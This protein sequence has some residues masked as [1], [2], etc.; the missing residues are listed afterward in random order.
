MSTPIPEPVSSA[1]RS[2]EQVMSGFSVGNLGGTLT[3]S[4]GKIQGLI[5]KI[6]NVVQMVFDELLARLALIMTCCTSFSVCISNLQEAFCQKP[7]ASP[8]LGETFKQF[9]A[10][11][12][13]TPVPVQ[14]HSVQAH[15]SK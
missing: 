10:T 14:A 7:V 12:N 1:S 2:A 3:E 5:V 9:M 4:V 13:A 8:A 15:P 11:L 6:Q